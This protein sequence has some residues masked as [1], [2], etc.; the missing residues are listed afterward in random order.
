M[1]KGLTGLESDINDSSLVSSDGISDSHDGVV[2]SLD[3]SISD[4]GDL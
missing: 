1:K 3:L 4:F 2:V